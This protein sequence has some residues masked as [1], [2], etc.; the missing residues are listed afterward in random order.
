M[1][2][3]ISPVVA[4]AT[5][6]TPISAAAG[7]Q[8]GKNE[9]LKLLVAQMTHQDPLNPMNGQEMATQLAQ[10]SS[11]EQL[12]NLGSKLDAQSAAYEAML[13]VVNNSAAVGLIGRTALVLSDVV[14]A[15]PNGSTRA[16]V[17]VPASGGRGTLRVLDANGT[18]L[19]TVDLGR[20]APGEREIDLE[21]ALDNLP[22]GPYRI[23]VDLDTP[24][25]V[26]PLETRIAVAVD[27]VAL[28]NGGAHITA[29]PVSY[30]IGVI[31]SVR[32]SRH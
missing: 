9:F 32:A 19:R 10:F 26:L 5:T 29:G 13:G 28:S 31:E 11:V 22:A 21:D 6:S 8:L 14:A 30:P 12:M 2:A 7:G 3:P 15:G 17:V 20:L 25:G 27:G 4:G 18:T 23:A 16:D 1:T 24:D